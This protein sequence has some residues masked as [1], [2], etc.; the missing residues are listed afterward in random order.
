MTEVSASEAAADDDG[1]E[2]EEKFLAL[3]KVF[4]RRNFVVKTLFRDADVTFKT[5]CL[6]K[7]GFEFRGQSRICFA[8]PIV[9]LNCQFTGLRLLESLV[10]F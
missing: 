5:I 7:L 3:K 2:S 4:V 1:D 10:H 6:E 8:S 9:E